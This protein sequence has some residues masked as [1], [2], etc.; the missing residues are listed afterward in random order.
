MAKVDIAKVVVN[1]FTRE[2]VEQYILK[3]LSTLH[4]DLSEAGD[5]AMSV[6]L[7]L[8]RA[9]RLKELMKALVDKYVGKS[10][11]MVL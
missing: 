9:E 4:Y 1:S 7:A 3:E 5:F 6:G 2:E 10:D 8:A 11:G